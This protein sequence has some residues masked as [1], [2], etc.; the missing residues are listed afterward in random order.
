MTHGFWKITA[1]SAALLLGAATVSAYAASVGVGVS[2][3]TATGSVGD[4]GASVGVSGANNSA[5]ATV[6]TANGQLATVDSN[7]TNSTAAVNLGTALGALGIGDATS[8][9]TG[10]D[11]IGTNAQVAAAISG[12]S[13]ADQQALK[14][15]CVDVT[16][17]PKM[18]K[19]DVVALCAIVAKI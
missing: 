9:G 17:S 13:D 2:G 14:V 18:Y 5:V 1:L 8:T 15:R 4:S 19:H 3:A 11:G 16:A 12:L 10:V 7:G 6:S